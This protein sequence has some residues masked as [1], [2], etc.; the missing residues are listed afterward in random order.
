MKETP[1]GGLFPAIADTSERSAK[2][3]AAFRTI[4]EV[5]VELLAQSGDHC[6]ASIKKTPFSMIC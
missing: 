2:S 5:A 4:S 1:A 3:D 6:Y